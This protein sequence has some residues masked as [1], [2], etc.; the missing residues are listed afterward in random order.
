MYSESGSVFIEPLMSNSHLHRLHFTYSRRLLINFEN[1]L[2]P[3]NIVDLYSEAKYMSKHVAHF[4][5]T[6]CYHEKKEPS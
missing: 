5:N 1:S 3:Q 2:D 4:F 6:L